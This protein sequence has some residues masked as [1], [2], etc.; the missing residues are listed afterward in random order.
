MADILVPFDFSKNATIA[1]DQAL[2]ISAA[3]NKK[4]EVLHITNDVV[5]KEYPKSWKYSEGQEG[6]ITD[7]IG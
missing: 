3:N 4:L 5:S 7:K 6:K 2:L 1:L